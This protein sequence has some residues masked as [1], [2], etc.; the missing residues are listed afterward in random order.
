VTGR[1]VEPLGG[2]GDA[3]VRPPQRPSPIAWVVAA[4]VVALVIAFLVVNRT[5]DVPPP[6]D[7][8]SDPTTTQRSAP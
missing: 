4:V 7:R 5:D 1:Y 3:N 8:P 2:P 6:G